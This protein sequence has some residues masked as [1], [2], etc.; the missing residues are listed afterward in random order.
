MEYSAVVAA[1]PA[2]CHCQNELERDMMDLKKPTVEKGQRDGENLDLKRSVL[3]HLD[4]AEENAFHLKVMFTSGMGF[5]TDAYDLWIIGVALLFIVPQF[6][7]SAL[8]IGILTSASLFGAFVGPLIFGPMADMFGRKYVYGVEMLVLAIGSIASALAPTFAFL[9]VMRIVM[10]LGIGG[11]YPTSATIMS[12]YSNAKNRGKLVSM[13]FAMQGAGI[14]AGIVLAFGLIGMHIGSG[15]IWRI[16]LGAGAIPAI[17]VIYF[18]RTILETPRYSLA[19]G[20]METTRKAVKHASGVDISIDGR[21]RDERGSY[22]MLRQYLPLLAGTSLTWML[23]DMSYYGTGI[24]TPT[25]VTLFGFS[26]ALASV[27]A[28]ALIFAL[29]AVPGYIFAVALMDREGRRLMQASGFFIIGILFLLLFAM[30][31]ALS[32]FEGAF[33][34]IYAL[35]FFFTNFGPNTTT[36]VY[37][38]EIF[39]TKIRATSHGISASV[40]KLGAAI[41]TLFFP[42]MLGMLGRYNIMAF[43]A[44][45]AMAGGIL[46]LVLLPETKLSCIN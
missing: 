9:V 4:E 15:I 30:G 31:G 18:R 34:P 44:L 7:P 24:F 14:I 40:G 10:G 25:L 35:T 20:D 26:G 6:H 5:F 23:M 33:L 32:A 43:L 16:M 8:W 21:Y 39:P 28:S 27:R 19:K 46:T 41:S 42:T 12:E 22:A 13:V 17:A 37:P 1:K 2:I 3:R 38:V 11:D 29:G 45:L 36:F